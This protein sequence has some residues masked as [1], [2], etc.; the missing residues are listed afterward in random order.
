MSQAEF[1]VLIERQIREGM[2]DYSKLEHMKDKLQLSVDRTKL[3]IERL[4]AVLEATGHK[5]ITLIDPRRCSSVKRPGNRAKDYPVRQEQ[6]D[7]MPVWDIISQILQQEPDKVLHGNDIA[8]QLYEI[9][10][11]S[12]L[13]RVKSSLLSQLYRGAKLNLWKS[14]GHNMYQASTSLAPDKEGN[15]VSTLS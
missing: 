7:G 6:W 9:E 8:R 4:N 2:R 14:L 11:D 5:R 13:V 10:K 15:L 3:Y 1:A 12:D